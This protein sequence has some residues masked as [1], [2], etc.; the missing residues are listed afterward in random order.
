MSRS[1]IHCTSAKEDSRLAA[2]EHLL[3]ITED[4]LQRLM[5][6]EGIS[7]SG[8][9]AATPQ[10]QHAAT[11]SAPSVSGSVASSIPASRRSSVAPQES[12]NVN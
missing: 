3:V 5:D 1:Y 7:S 10:S 9:L 4:L 8:W 2:Y 6:A 12:D 11:Y